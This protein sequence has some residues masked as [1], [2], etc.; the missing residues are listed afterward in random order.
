MIFQQN[1]KAIQ[2]EN[3]FCF[4]KIGVVISGYPYDRERQNLGSHLTSH[5]KVISRSI[6][7]LIIKTKNVNLIGKKLGKYFHGFVVTHKFVRETIEGTNHGK[8][9]D[10]LDLTKS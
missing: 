4:S 5:K 6:I 3:N 10:K 2:W 1:A 9:V 8:V 7:D